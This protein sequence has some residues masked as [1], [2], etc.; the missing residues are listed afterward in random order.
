MQ[1]KQV[2]KSICYTKEDFISIRC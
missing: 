2:S 1:P